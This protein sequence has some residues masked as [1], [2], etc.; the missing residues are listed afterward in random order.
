[1]LGT[2]YLILQSY[3]KVYH[4]VRKSHKS[5]SISKDFVSNE[6]K[7]GLAYQ[8]WCC[9]FK[10]FIGW[11]RA[12]TFFDVSREV[13]SESAYQI[14]TDANPLPSLPGVCSDSCGELFPVSS[15]RPTARAP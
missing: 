3:I 11:M 9:K 1:M 5:A 6:V 4:A 2:L 7:C 12:A 8:F 13:S 14:E 10:L 15:R